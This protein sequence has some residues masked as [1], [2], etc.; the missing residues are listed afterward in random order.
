MIA[1][2]DYG[3][4]NLFSIYN[5]LK[6]VYDEPRLVTAEN[7]ARLKEAE[8][9][10]VPGVGAFDDGIRNLKPFSEALLDCVGSGVPV[11]GICIG[12]QVLFE[13]SEE[14]NEK[15]L[16][17]IPGTV[18]RLPRTVRVPHMGWNNLHLRKDS[19]LLDG[20]TGEDY[21]YFVHSYHCVPRDKECI[22]ASVEYGVQIT[23]VVNKMNLYG[24]QFHPEKSSKRGLQLLKN[25]VRICTG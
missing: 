24:V 19:A 5:G 20:I 4:G 15:G 6:R 3:M 12:M 14:G 18:V 1:I 8:G 16:G 25:F 2:I 22:I 23:A 13:A 7:I 17:L 10:I 9:V 21:F 11:L